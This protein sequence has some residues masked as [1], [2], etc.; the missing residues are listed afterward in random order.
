LQCVHP[1]RSQSNTHSRACAGR[2]R[3]D[4]P[5]LTNC[6][7]PPRSVGICVLAS[8]SS[9]IILRGCKCGAAAAAAWLTRAASLDCL[10]AACAAAAC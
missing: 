5:S 2:W 4:A 8:G 7:G 1:A 10:A 3:D 9:P 6:A